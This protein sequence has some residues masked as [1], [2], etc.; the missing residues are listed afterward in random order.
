MKRI[1]D[2]G[3]PDD[4]DNESDD[5]KKASNEYSDCFETEQLNKIAKLAGLSP[6][7][8]I[9]PK[10]ELPLLFRAG[11]GSLGKVSIYIKSKSQME[12]DSKQLEDTDDEE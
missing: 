6:N 11:I 9:Y 1:T 7:I 2:F 10:E 5:E 8:H 4:S 12:R 3:E